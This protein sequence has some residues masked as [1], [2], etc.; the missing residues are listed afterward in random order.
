MYELH[1]Y[2]LKITFDLLRVHTLFAKMSK[3]SFGATHVEYLG[4]IISDKG[5]AIDLKKIGAM[6]NWPSLVTVKALFLWVVKTV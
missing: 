5:V 3:C 6:V 1:L 4:H 2:H